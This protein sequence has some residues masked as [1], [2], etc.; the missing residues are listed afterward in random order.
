MGRGRYV[1]T[2]LDDYSRLSVIRILRA[3]DHAAA[4]VKEVFAQLERQSG[5]KV[6]RVRT[7][8]GGEY[9][10]KEL[11]DFFKECGVVH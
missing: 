3:K 7:D 1:A 11:Q 10:G 6:K 9:M 2:F 5:C 8:R 4:I